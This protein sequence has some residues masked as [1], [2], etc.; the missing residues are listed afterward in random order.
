MAIIVHE[1]FGF[2]KGKG[3]MGY[4]FNYPYDGCV[5]DITNQRFAEYKR[6]VKDE[7]LM[8]FYAT[9]GL[10]FPNRIRALKWKDIKEF[11]LKGFGNENL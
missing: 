5:F 8:H 2:N 4:Q 10:L 7:D 3:L 9:E 11:V 6:G 1:T